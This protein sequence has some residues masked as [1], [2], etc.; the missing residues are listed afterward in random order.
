MNLRPRRWRHDRRGTNRSRGYLSIRGGAGLKMHTAVGARRR[1]SA[2]CFLRN[3]PTQVT[4]NVG[5]P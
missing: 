5:F 1:I 3:E 4:E 2:N